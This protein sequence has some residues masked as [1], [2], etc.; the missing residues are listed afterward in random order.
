MYLAAFQNHFMS[1]ETGSSPINNAISIFQTSSQIVGIENG[2]FSSLGQA[3]GTH[4]P[5][6][7]VCDRQDTRTAERSCGNLILRT[8]E[9]R[10]SRQEWNQMLSY[11]DRAYTRTAATV[12]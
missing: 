6:V 2:Y 3:F 4:H 9:D 5:D 11:T 10:M 12:W 8:A 7:A 1:D